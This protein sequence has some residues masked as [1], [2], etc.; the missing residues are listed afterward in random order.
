[1][2]LLS[3][4]TSRDTKWMMAPQ[5]SD[6]NKLELEVLMNVSGESNLGSLNHNHPAHV[7]LFGLKP[8]LDHQ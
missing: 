8:Q 6:V 4:R 2:R 7:Q 1:M 3:S 5:Y